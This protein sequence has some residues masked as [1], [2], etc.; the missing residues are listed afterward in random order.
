MLVV[1]VFFSS[2]RRHTRCGRDWSSDVCSSD[3]GARSFS[4]K[5]VQ[6]LAVKKTFGEISV[7]EQI[8]KILPVVGDLTM[9]APELLK[10]LLVSTKPETMAFTRDGVMNVT[11]AARASA[12]ISR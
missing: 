7:P 11:V 10:K 8:G 3:L 1:V 12:R 2:R 4:K 5:T 9:N 6:W